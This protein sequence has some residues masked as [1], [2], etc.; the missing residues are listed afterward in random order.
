MTYGQPAA[1]LTPKR[2][3]FG[4]EGSQHCWNLVH[5]STGSMENKIQQLLLVFTASGP[6]KPKEA[7]FKIGGSPLVV[8]LIRLFAHCGVTRCV[9]VICSADTN[10]RQVVEDICERVGIQLEVIG[11]EEAMGLSPGAEVSHMAGILAAKGHFDGPFLLASTAHLFCPSLVDSMQKALNHGVEDVLPGG[12]AAMVVLAETQCERHVRLVPTC[13][14]LKLENDDANGSIA[15]GTANCRSILSSE[16]GIDGRLVDAGRELSEFGAVDAGLFTVEPKPFFEAVETLLHSASGARSPS[17]SERDDPTSEAGGSPGLLEEGKSVHFANLLQTL[18]RNS[19]A[20]MILTQGRPWYCVEQA[21]MAAMLSQLVEGGSWVG[22]GVSTVRVHRSAP[23][24]TGKRLLQEKSKDQDPVLRFLDRMGR[25][26]EFEA[27]LDVSLPASLFYVCDVREI[28]WRHCVQLARTALDEDGDASLSNHSREQSSPTPSFNALTSLL[29][30][31]RAV[32]QYFSYPGPDVLEHLQ[33]LVQRGELKKVL[34]LLTL[35]ES[36]VGRPELGAELPNLLVH[37]DK[38]ED[39]EANLRALHGRSDDQYFELLVVGRMT[40]D[41]EA[42]LRRALREQRTQRDNVAYSIC[43]VPSFEDAIAAVLFNHMIQAVLIMQDFDFESTNELK[44]IQ[45]FLGPSEIV[46]LRAEADIGG[47]FQRTRM[48]S[49]LSKKIHELLPNLDMF[50][51]GGL[52]DLNRVDSRHFKRVFHSIEQDAVEMHLSIVQAVQDRAVTPFFSALIAYASKPTG[53]FHALPLSRGNSVYN[54]QWMRDFGDF[55]GQNI[56][57]AETSATI[58]GLDSLL[59]P[60]G[61]IKQ[62]QHLA[63]RTFGAQQTFFATNGT[64]TANKIVLQSLIVPGDI[65]MIDRN[66]HKSHHYGAVLQGANIVYLEAYPVNEYALY[67][68]V[69]QQHVLDALKAHQRAGT[70]DRVKLVLLTNCTFDGLVYNVQLL[71]ERCLAIK[72]D[73][74][75]LWDEAWFAFAA[76]TPT[77]RKRT[78]MH[79]AKV[80]RQRYRSAQYRDE[81]NAAPKGTL[82]D[83]DKVR[84]RVYSTQSTHKTLSAFRQGSMIHI[85]DDLFEREVEMPFHEAYM[86]HTSTSPN[87]QIIASLDVARRQVAMEGFAMVQRSIERAM[88]LRQAI[89]QDA[90]LSKYFH[91]LD[92]TDLVPSSMRGPS[93]EFAYNPEAGFCGMDDVWATDEV[94]L[95]P[96]RLTLFVG[97]TGL[98]GDT[99]KRALM[100]QHG[101]QVN[102]TSINT[103]LFMTNIGTTLSAVSHLHN[104]LA[105]IALDLE[106]QAEHTSMAMM[107]HRNRRVAELQRSLP[108]LPDFTRFHKKFA[109][110]VESGVTME[111][112]HLPGNIRKAYFLAYKEENCEYLMWDVIDER[113]KQGESMVGATFIIPYPPGFPVVV[114][115][116]EI[117]PHIIKFMRALDVSE[118]HGFVA[119]VGVKVFKQ[120]VLQKL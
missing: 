98:D 114:P 36:T 90:L 55:Y 70:L 48:V 18:A 9:S 27:S 56:L 6:A 83:P 23:M 116:Q 60:T 46:R 72:P 78:G 1:P 92:A 52:G 99:F 11:A 8:H 119:G 32:Q 91:F 73:L 112:R 33:T 110:P 57:L 31:I 86:T 59:D 106:E 38:S 25:M 7:L 34:K 81:Y 17:A 107:L 41:M 54:S 87:Y 16:S 85:H 15:D 37:A 26:A 3:P 49:T 76:F 21:G 67:G 93:T 47:R 68:T 113:L 51:L 19:Q 65:V 71:M 109:M 94:V 45:S 43:V 10:L 104:T 96:T 13:A 88:M 103:V 120:E 95:D 89:K 29:G 111:E 97:R 105:K 58:G 63:A 79:S 102:K 108:P 42:G 64:S 40:P 14:R 20:G 66:C 28:L 80:L 24:Q 69:P 53:V 39:G 30:V 118:V 62:A 115:G 4:R 117:S 100:D 74:V 12:Q 2:P 50:H 77:Y 61:V 101:I 44:D 5:S 84:V 22:P 35:I 82:P 75:F